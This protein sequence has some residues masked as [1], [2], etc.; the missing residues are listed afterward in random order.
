MASPDH[1]QQPSTAGLALPADLARVAR[2]SW[3][4]A[5][6]SQADIAV[7]ET[8]WDRAYPSFYRAAYIDTAQRIGE[9]ATQC[10][11]DGKGWVLTSSIARAA[12]E[13]VG[14]AHRLPVPVPE[15][16][17]DALHYAAEVSAP[18]LEPWR[19][20][21]ETVWNT[22]RI[23]A[24]IAGAYAAGMYITTHQSVRTGR[25]V[26]QANGVQFDGQ[27]A[28]PWFHA[29]LLTAN[30]AVIAPSSIPVTAAQLARQ[31]QAPGA[32]ANALHATADRTNRVQ[33]APGTPA[34]TVP[35]TR[36]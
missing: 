1:R 26:A 14:H 2:E 25:S 3:F 6:A 27:P 18:S 16:D 21:A 10:R 24:T 29:V 12:S 5:R 13:V 15:F 20:L 33:H 22:A 36:R 8:I 35:V 32:A 34:A 28:E 23:E 17:E 9:A 19:A 30:R 11:A 4:S 31:S 7:A